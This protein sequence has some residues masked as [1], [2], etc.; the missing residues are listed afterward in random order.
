[1]TRVGA[2]ALAGVGALGL[3]AGW[4]FF[5]ADAGPPRGGAPG[6]DDLA[7]VTALLDGATS[8]PP[9]DVLLAGEG[10]LYLARASER[11]VVAVAKKG[12]ATR[13]LAKLDTPAQGMALAGGALWVTTGRALEKIAVTGGEPQAVA[14]GLTRPR[15]VASDGRWVFVVDVDAN[16][17]G[18][19][20][21]SAVVRIPAE[22]GERVTLGR[23]EGEIPDLALDDAN[24]YWADRLEGTLVSVPK[25][26]GAPRVVA[27]ERGLP[28]SVVVAGDALTWVE[29]RSESVWTVPRSGGTPR[30]V[31]QDFAGFANLVVDARGLFWTNEAAVEGGFRVLTAT[32]SGDAK[33]V[34]PV[35]D[36]VA[37]LASDGARLYWER[38]G[39]VEEVP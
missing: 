29:K 33:P 27:S 36:A 24:V 14:V 15:A 12:G 26:G 17:T 32:E 21:G 22:G 5:S 4:W 28:G 35:V 38:G 30:R 34:S 19:T 10:E 25:A 20:R 1:M 13:A 9:R 7:L 23:S 8:E 16:R 39:V 31:A 2:A 37:A 18:M 6:D 3:L 11:T